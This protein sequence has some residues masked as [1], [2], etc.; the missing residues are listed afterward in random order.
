[1]NPMHYAL[2]AD[3]VVIVHLLFVIFVV[4]GGLFV[5]KWRWVA[6]LHVPAAVWGVTLECLG[7]I[8]PLTPLELRLRALAGETGYAAGFVEHYLL[9]VLYPAGLTREIQLLLG[10]LVI[11]INAG[12]YLHI[13]RQ[14]YQNR[15]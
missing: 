12:I 2:L 15:G 1:M 3:A 8:C 4:A 13:L 9:P 5:L 6:W 10:G 14:M 7:L 11:L